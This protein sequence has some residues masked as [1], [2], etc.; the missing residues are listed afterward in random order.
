MVILKQILVQIE[1][2]KSF[3][4]CHWNVNSLTAHNIVKLFSI[5]YLKYDF[6]SE[7]YLDSSAQ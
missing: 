5:V 6:I 1:N 4:C 2:V 7:T 3:S